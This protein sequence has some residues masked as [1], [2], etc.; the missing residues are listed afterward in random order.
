MILQALCE[1]YDRKIQ[2]GEMAPDGFIEKKL[3]FVVY[4]EKDGSYKSIEDL[5]E[6]QGKRLVGKTYY[7][8]A[9]GKQAQKHTNSGKDANLLWDN[10][11]FALG[12]G[13]NG[14]VKLKSFIDTIRAF[15][16]LPPDDVKALLSF[17]ENEKERNVAVELMLS[18]D[19]YGDELGTGSPVISFRIGEGACI[20]EQP[21]VREAMLQNVKKFL[22]KRDTRSF[23]YQGEKMYRLR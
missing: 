13:K 3:D 6:P 4:L 19:T 9:I 5:R 8:P 20:F 21:H 15:Y 17:L 7:V 14:D 1:Y 2:K 12:V 18:N 16:H 10:S 22:P 23:L 11:A